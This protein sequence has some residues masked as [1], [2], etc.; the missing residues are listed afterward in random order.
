MPWKLLP[1]ARRSRGRFFAV[2]E[3]EVYACALF[4][5]AP[6]RSDGESGLS[7]DY[8]RV[9]TNID[10]PQLHQYPLKPVGATPRNVALPALFYFLPFLV[11]LFFFVTQTNRALRSTIVSMGYRSQVTLDNRLYYALM[12]IECDT[13]DLP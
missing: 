2:R 12:Y 5:S 6:I 7:A 1:L 8:G 13:F 11:S 9:C 3:I 4:L 10:D